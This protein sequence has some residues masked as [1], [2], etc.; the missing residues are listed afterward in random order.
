M[1]LNGTLLFKYI[2]LFY[3]LII[4]HLG[5]QMQRVMCIERLLT[6]FEMIDF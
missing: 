5:E 3:E 4:E 2:D 1:L 6:K